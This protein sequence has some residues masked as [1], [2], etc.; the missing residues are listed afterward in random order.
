MQFPGTSDCIVLCSLLTVAFKLRNYKYKVYIHTYDWYISLPRLIPESPRWL[1]ARNRDEEARNIIE[2]MAR[3][4]GV[5]VPKMVDK[6]T[7][8]DVRTV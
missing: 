5:Q 3:V 8:V 6:A 1:F 7:Q 4:N 2:R